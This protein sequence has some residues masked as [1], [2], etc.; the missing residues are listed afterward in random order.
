MT[1]EIE[2]AGIP[3]AQI[4]AMPTVA[5]AWGPNRII[6]GQGIVFPVGDSSLPAE[7]ERELRRRL[8]REALEALATEVG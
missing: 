2:K 4:T 5:Q 3:V 1:L 8:V 6:K 7:E